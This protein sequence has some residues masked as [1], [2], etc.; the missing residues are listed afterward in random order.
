MV[1][2]GLYLKLYMDPS[3]D[4]RYIPYLSHI[5]LSEHVFSSNSHSIGHNSVSRPG[6]LLEEKGE[7]C[8]SRMASK[9][10]SQES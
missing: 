9:A 1:N 8:M 7:A 10:M 4:L 5:R 2:Q 6:S 3:S